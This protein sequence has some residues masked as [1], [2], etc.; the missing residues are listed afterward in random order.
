M[1]FW[2][3]GTERVCQW[4]L[5][6]GH[7]CALQRQVLL[8]LLWSLPRGPPLIPGYDW[9]AWSDAQGQPIQLA[10]P[11]S[12]DGESGWFVVRMPSTDEE[13]WLYGTSFERLAHARPG[14]I[15]SACMLA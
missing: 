13:G 14:A 9:P 7:A 2:D 10:R 6:C 12:I 11:P 8:C 15:S 5:E 3:L 4:C 1:G